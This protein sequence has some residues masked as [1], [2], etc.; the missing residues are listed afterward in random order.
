MLQLPITPPPPNLPLYMP[1]EK[2]TRRINIIE[3]YNFFGNFGEISLENCGTHREENASIIIKMLRRRC[4][5][6]YTLSLYKTFGN[7]TKTYYFTLFK[8]GYNNI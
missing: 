5:L 6:V 7:T 4:W 3:K 2:R 8:V 1:T